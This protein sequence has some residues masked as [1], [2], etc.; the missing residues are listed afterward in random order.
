MAGKSV[1]KI[2]PSPGFVLVLPESEEKMTV[3]GIVLPESHEE[4]PQAGRVI[5]VGGTVTTDFGTK[6]SSPCKVGDRVVFKK[7][8]GSE[9]KPED[10]DKEYL[11]VKFDEVLAVIK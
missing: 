3:S 1:N 7:W 8:A 5:S 9:Y 4:K 2:V 11:F 10:E 6:L